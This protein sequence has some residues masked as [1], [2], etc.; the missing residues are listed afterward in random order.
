MDQNDKKNKPGGS[1]KGGNVRGIVSLVSWALLLTI[2]I[3]YASTYMTS[4]GHQS[5]SVTIPYSVFKDM[6]VTD[7]VDKVEFDTS[8]NILHITPADA[9]K[10]ARP[11]TPTPAPT[12][13]STPC[14]W[15]FSACSWSPT[16]R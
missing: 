5:S 11:S 14:S 8:E 15:I 9:A 13:R 6:V 10:R 1:G 16:T 4:A 7:D 12:V 3:S 2:L